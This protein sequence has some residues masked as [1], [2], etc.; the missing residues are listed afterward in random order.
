MKK[1]AH[2]MGGRWQVDE[3]Y[4]VTPLTP[5]GGEGKGTNAVHRGPGGLS[6][7]TNYTSTGAMG[8]YHGTGITTWSPEEKVYK[9]FWVDNGA[10][11][12]E[13]WT[14]KWDA[15][16]LVF[17]T[18]EKMGEQT[19]HWRETY[20]AV[21]NDSFT[22]AFDMGPFETDM[23]RFMTFKFTRMAKQSAGMRRHGTGMH[24]RPTS[25]GWG[26]PRAEGSQNGPGSLAMSR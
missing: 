24:G 6:L 25:D 21:T 15:E 17:T 7:I 20:L 2:L 10:Q 1:L 19:I 11:G 22:V 12:G 13:L 26:G 3:K 5:Q 23:K 4:E 9:Q 16:T 8:E 18:T 14:G